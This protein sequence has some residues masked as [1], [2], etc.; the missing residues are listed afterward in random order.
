M[1]KIGTLGDIVFSVSK[2]TIRTFNELQVQSKTSYA[3][4]ERQGK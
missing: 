1:A 3:N 2:K 4:H